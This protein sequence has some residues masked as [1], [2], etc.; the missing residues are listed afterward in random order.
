MVP[1]SIILKIQWNRF[2][3]QHQF[4]EK[5]TKIQKNKRVKLK[6]ANVLPTTVFQN[7]SDKISSLLT[8]FAVVLVVND[9]IPFL[10]IKNNLD[11]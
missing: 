5:I 10:L 11:N 2:F 8:A 9:K 4:V 3:V 7:N 1:L 6:T